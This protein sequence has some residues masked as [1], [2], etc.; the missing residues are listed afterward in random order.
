MGSTQSTWGI[1][2]R[3]KRNRSIFWQWIRA[4]PCHRYG[5]PEYLRR[6]SPVARP[7]LTTLTTYTGKS[8]NQKKSKYVN[9]AASQRAQPLVRMSRFYRLL[10][11]KISKTTK[12]KLVFHLNRKKKKKKKKKS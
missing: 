11:Q 12:E 10:A 9:S 5:C 7:A 6:T 3:L 2:F 4:D 8:K 1:D